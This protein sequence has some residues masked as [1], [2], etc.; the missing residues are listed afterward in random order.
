MNTIIIIDLVSKVEYSVQIDVNSVLPSG[1]G[2][3]EVA[4]K[5]WHPK[6]TFVTAQIIK[7]K[8]NDLPFFDEVSELSYDIKNNRIIKKFVES[9]E[10]IIITILEWI[11]EINKEY[12]EEEN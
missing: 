5:V 3:K 2:H 10:E 6:H 11:E 9:N 8:S 12:S 1:H 4:F 7:V